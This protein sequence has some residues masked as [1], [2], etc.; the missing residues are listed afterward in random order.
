VT[1]P[2]T[3][4]EADVAL[5]LGAYAAWER[6]D[7]DAAVAPLH[8]EVVWIEPEEFPGGGERRGPAAV[9]DYL[10]D[11]RAGWR[12]LRSQRRASTV[13]GDVAVVHHVEGILGDGTP[14]ETTVADVFTVR[15]GQV[16]HMQAYADAD[17]PFR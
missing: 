1:T 2:D 11:S 8:P 10:R 9:A 15:D 13:G 3:P 5:V 4:T 16:V 7:I 17:A 14:H 6:G 12:E